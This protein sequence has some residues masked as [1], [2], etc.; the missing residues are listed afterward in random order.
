MLQRYVTALLPNL[1][2]TE[3]VTEN[4]N[5]ISTLYQSQTGQ[6]LALANYRATTVSSLVAFSL[7]TDKCRSRACWKLRLA[8]LRVLPTE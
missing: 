7:R 6:K 3:L 5:E 4:L 1:Y 8:S 2:K